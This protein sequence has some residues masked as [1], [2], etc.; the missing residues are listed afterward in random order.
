[1]R[2]L[3]HSRGKKRSTARA[4][5]RRHLSDAAS[6]FVAELLESRLLLS[7][8]PLVIQGSAAD[9][10]FLVR[11]DAAKSLVV[12]YKLFRDASHLWAVVDWKPGVVYGHRTTL[13]HLRGVIPPTI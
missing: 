6:K 12:V 4:R 8:S 3:L 13:V 7:Q 2:V 10:T 1:M 9:D 11:F 5:A